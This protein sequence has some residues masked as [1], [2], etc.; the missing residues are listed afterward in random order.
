MIRSVVATLLTAASLAALAGPPS[1]AVAACG[2]ARNGASAAAAITPEAR[3]DAK[4]LYAS[5]CA[6]CHGKSGRG[7]GP[8]ASNLNPRPPDFCDR[9]WQKSISDEKIARAIVYGGAAVGLTSQ[10]APNPDLE[11]RPAVVAAFVEHIR[12]LGK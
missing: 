5:R 1:A 7:D 3:V 10:M 12:K 2:G 11:D 9:K 4:R 6:V 8:G